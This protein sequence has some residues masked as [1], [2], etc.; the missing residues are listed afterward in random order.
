[1][2]PVTENHKG[3]GCAAGSRSALIVPAKSGNWAH[4]DPAEGRGA[5]RGGNHVE[6]LSRG[7]EPATCVHDKTW[8]AGLTSRPEMARSN[9]G[10]RCERGR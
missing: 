2:G 4:R 1:M 5:P 10:C 8:V 7:S 6:R 3:A 9:S